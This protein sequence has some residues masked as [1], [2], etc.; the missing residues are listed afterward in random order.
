MAARP[1]KTQQ[2]VKRNN[3]DIDQRKTEEMSNEKNEATKA[4]STAQLAEE[5]LPPLLLVFVVLACS[6]LLWVF[7][8]RDILSTGRIIA[9]SWDEAFQVYM[10]V[11]VV[12][13]VMTCQVL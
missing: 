9:S 12:S 4:A 13:H 11:C 3:N 6:G 5:H 1:R 10:I 2:A 7:A 8:L